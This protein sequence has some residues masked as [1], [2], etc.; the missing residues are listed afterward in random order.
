MLLA[1]EARNL[2]KTER[3]KREALADKQEVEDIY[4]ILYP[5]TLHF[6]WVRLLCAYCLPF[7][8]CDGKAKAVSKKVLVLFVFKGYVFFLIIRM[9]TAT[10]IRRTRIFQM[11]SLWFRV[12]QWFWCQFFGDLSILQSNKTHTLT[13]S[14]L[15]LMTSLMTGTKLWFTFCCEFVGST[16]LGSPYQL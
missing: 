11:R 12:L 15:R 10:P 8:Y 7:Y 1:A 6:H 13:Q 9:G 2:M 14:M 5:L 4:W 16:F 3:R